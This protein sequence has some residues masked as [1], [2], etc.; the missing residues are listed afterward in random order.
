MSQSLRKQ[1]NSYGSINSMQGMGASRLAQLGFGGRW[2]LAPTA[3]AGRS[4]KRVFWVGVLVWEPD[5]R[6]WG[7]VDEDGG[8]IPMA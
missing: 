5:G 6:F 8:G 4:G 7:L 3:D 1:R 2:W